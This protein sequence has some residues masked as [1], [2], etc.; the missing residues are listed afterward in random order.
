[1]SCYLYN[2]IYFVFVS[3]AY[4][5]QL[6]HHCFFLGLQFLSLHFLVNKYFRYSIPV[7]ILVAI[8]GLM[9]VGSTLVLLI[10]SSLLSFFLNLI[11][12]PILLIWLGG[13]SLVRSLK[14]TVVFFLA[15]FV[16][17][18]LI[19]VPARWYA[20]ELFEVTGVSM[21]PTYVVGDSVVI[22]KLSLDYRSGE[23]VVIKNPR[24]HFIYRIIGSP[25]DT[26][27]IFE[28]QVLLNGQVLNEPYAYGKNGGG[29]IKEILDEGEYFVMGD[30]REKS[31]D[32]RY[33]GVVT[34]DQI[35]GKPF[36]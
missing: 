31:A 4:I 17:L 15:S 11:T 9:I 28:D 29:P 36:F 12:L 23:V 32:S 25:G 8:F 6:Y 7:T 21:E 34:T 18:I 27:E 24:G 14:T 5:S 2:L 3:Y 16:L 10:I 20:V 33:W 13:L 22:D 26:I 19:T 35:I 1:M 30:N